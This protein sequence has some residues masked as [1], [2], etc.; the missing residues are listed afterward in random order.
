MIYPMVTKKNFQT[1]KTPKI[2]KIKGAVKIMK[3][4]LAK[5][6]FWLQHIFIK[7]WII[8]KT[9]LYFLSGSNV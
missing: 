5:V 4:T 7:N 1:I 6:Q 3:S 2:D 8:S 9:H